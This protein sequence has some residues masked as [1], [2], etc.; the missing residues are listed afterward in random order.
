[1]IKTGIIGSK[2]F[3]VETVENLLDIGEIK[4]IGYHDN[5]SH[6]HKSDPNKFNLKSYSHTKELINEVDAVIAMPPFSAP[7]KI[8]YFVKNS[9]HVFFELSTDYCKR[10]ASKLSAI[11][12][13]A[14][15]KVQVGFHHRFNNTFLSA[16]P[17]I[18]KPTFIQSGNYKKYHSGLQNIN[19]LL[20]MLVNDVDIVLSVIQSEVKNVVANVASIMP[21]TPDVINVRIEFLNGTVAQLTVGIIATE[22]SHNFGFYCNKDFIN[23]DFSQNKAWV[24]R[25]NDKANDLKLFQQSIGDLNVEPIIVKPNNYIYDEFSSFAKSIVYDKCPEVSIE[26]TLR[27]LSV[28]QQIK[29]KIKL[30]TC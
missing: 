6:T 30:S 16:K 24:I 10:E 3:C 18:N 27:T 14:N 13:E 26:S 25:K 15:V 8:S 28:I 9:K 11:I 12:D 2:E 22:D 1:M 7:E 21:G 19:V 5:S 20:E 29:D 4:L 17:F 23:I